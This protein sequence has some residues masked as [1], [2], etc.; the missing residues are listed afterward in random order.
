[1]LKLFPEVVI[2][3]RGMVA[4]AR[5]VM[6]T[7]LLLIGIVYIFALAIMQVAKG[8]E[9][10][11]NNFSSVGQ[12]MMSLI[13]RGV[14]PD[15]RELVE[16]LMNEEPI[17]GILSIIFVLIGSMML[18][19]MLIGILVEVVSAVS[20]MNK[21]QAEIEYAKRQMT[22]AFETL[23]TNHDKMIC[24][25]EISRLLEDPQAQIALQSMDID[26]LG[27]ADMT[28][29]IFKDRMSLPLPEFMEEV[30]Q[31]RGTNVAKVKDIVDL[32]NFMLDTF[33]FMLREMKA[34]TVGDRGARKIQRSPSQEW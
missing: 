1:M 27:L 31:L 30:L 32:R 5:S 34:L 15:Q 28:D 26:V 10:G 13:L 18:M 33:D 14:I 9:Y 20:A 8:T 2:L 21:E 11:R 23:D 7:L 3:L 29:Y 16:E 6:V 4:A 12:A 17:L 25:T 22:L 19:N 24:M